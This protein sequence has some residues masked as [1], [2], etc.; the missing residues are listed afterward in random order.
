MVA[1]LSA[2]PSYSHAA[3]CAMLRRTVRDLTSPL[4]P[5]LAARDMFQAVH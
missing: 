5:R 2:N 1:E 3:R 4:P